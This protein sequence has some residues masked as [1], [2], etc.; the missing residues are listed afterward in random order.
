[1][2]ALTLMLFAGVFEGED[3]Q[4][5]AVSSYSQ[6]LDP[7]AAPSG[8][9]IQGQRLIETQNNATSP[10]GERASLSLWRNAAG[11]VQLDEMEVRS[12]LFS[13]RSRPHLGETL[14][15]GLLVGSWDEVLTHG[16]NK[17]ARWLVYSPIALH[18]LG[19]AR[20]D[21]DADDRLKYYAGGSTGLG[22]EATLQLI[23]PAGLHGRGETRLTSKNRWRNNDV[24]T[25]RHEIEV[26]MDLGVSWKHQNRQ[27]ILSAWGEKL[28]RWE[29][30]DDLGRNGVDRE[31]ESAGLRLTYRGYKSDSNTDS[32]L[33]AVL[34]RLRKSIEPSDPNAD[35]EHLAPNA[36][37][38][39]DPNAEALAMVSKTATGAAPLL[40]HWSEPEILKRFLPVLPEGI[41]EQDANCKLRFFI[42]S[43]GRPYEIKPEACAPPLL[44]P[45]MAAA[46]Q[47]RLVPFT[48][49]GEIHPIQFL[50]SV[51][52]QKS[53]GAP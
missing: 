33:D 8:L 7:F 48:E 11:E 10:T 44:G 21:M 42:D 28:W 26:A 35:L 39:L 18:L 14:D 38:P 16:Q 3:Y 52:W 53:Q 12:L 47:W 36:P 27:W 4:D 32:E 34:S 17:N 51:R 45:A 2:Y 23:G 37:I 50:Y 24:N 29:P 25:I 20:N 19:L 30:R 6:Q 43:E 5:V 46:W 15:I 41:S 40:V 13:M 22:G 49:R 9:Q 1:M 31:H